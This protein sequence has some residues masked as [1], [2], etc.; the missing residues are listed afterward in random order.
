VARIS[1]TV[2]PGARR[3]DLVGRHGDG[4]R[5]RIAAPP[6]RGRANEALCKLLAEALAV[7]RSSVRVVAGRSARAKVVEIDGLD[8]ADVDSRLSSAI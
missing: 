2:S 6:E 1:V 4:W 7:P 5:A 3:S 8:P